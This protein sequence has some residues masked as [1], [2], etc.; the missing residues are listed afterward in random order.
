MLAQTI[1]PALAFWALHLHSFAMLTT[2]LANPEVQSAKAHPPTGAPTLAWA[3]RFIILFYIIRLAIG[4]CATGGLHLFH[5]QQ[6][7]DPHVLL[8]HRS[9]VSS[10][11]ANVTMLR[12]CVCQDRQDG[13]CTAAGGLS[14]G[15]TG[16][17]AGGLAGGPAG[18]VIG[19]ASG[20]F[21]GMVEGSQSCDPGTAILR[22]MSHGVIAGSQQ[23]QSKPEKP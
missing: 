23:R 6:P 18:A 5:A 9:N 1:S 16:A 22:G 2:S 12:E 11:F 19:G 7:K 20:F 8:S 15:S 13:V 21:G 10:A 14:G 17:I 3:V 4:A